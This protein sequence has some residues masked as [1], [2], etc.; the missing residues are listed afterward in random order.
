MGG[1]YQALKPPS[2]RTKREG[3]AGD[4]AWRSSLRLGALS[5]PRR[6][7]ARAPASMGWSGLRL[8]MA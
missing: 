3:M 8:R 5:P 4:K 1:T 7:G 2:K 6:R